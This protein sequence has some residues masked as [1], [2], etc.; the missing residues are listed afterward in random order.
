M[1]ETH[2]AKPHAYRN[3]L[4][5]MKK[6][7]VRESF[8]WGS[9]VA[10]V[11]TLVF[12]YFSLWL[13]QKKNKIN[14]RLF[15]LIKCELTP[16]ASW[17][18]CLWS[19]RV[20]IDYLWNFSSLWLAVMITLVLVSR[21]SKPSEVRTW[22]RSELQ[23]TSW[24]FGIHMSSNTKSS[25]SV[26]LFLLQFLNMLFCCPF[27]RLLICS[28]LKKRPE[29]TKYSRRLPRMWGSEDWWCILISKILTGLVNL[30][31]WQLFSS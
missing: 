7:T 6:V 23:W 26:F 16:I 31:C 30:Y 3:A 29:S 13:V 24:A 27:C 21:H 2:A 8:I 11:N 18:V 5:H 14:T 9:K 20:L 19:L 12:S 28:L 15:R 17:T 25:R 1:R 4:W 22:R 10:S